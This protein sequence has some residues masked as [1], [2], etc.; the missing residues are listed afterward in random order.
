M[1][2]QSINP[3]IYTFQ[4]AASMA[5]GLQ[6]T[7]QFGQERKYLMACH[8][9]TA[10]SLQGEERNCG[11]C[12]SPKISIPRTHSGSEKISPGQLG[13]SHSTNHEI[14]SDQN[15]ICHL[16]STMIPDSTQLTTVELQVP[17]NLSQY[18]ISPKFKYFPFPQYTSMQVK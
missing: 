16:D 11:V 5:V 13:E 1:P 17:R 15:T 8:K 18:L 14:N 3:Q 7:P 10:M 9:I 4:E 2:N 12:Q 6:F